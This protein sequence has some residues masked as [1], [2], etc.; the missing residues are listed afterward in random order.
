MLK[1]RHIRTKIRWKKMKN[2]EKY[3][4]LK[5]KSMSILH[6]FLHFL[7]W[8]MIRIPINLSIILCNYNL[9]SLDPLNIKGCSL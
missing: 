8:Q 6:T 2:H 5:F 4:I 9:F 7:A 1:D 3:F